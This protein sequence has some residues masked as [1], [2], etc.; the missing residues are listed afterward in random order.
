[1]ADLIIWNYRATRHELG[2]PA[3]NNLN[4][5]R[6]LGPHQL[7]CTLAKSGYE[8]KVIDF[9]G[10]MSTNDLV[11]ITEK[12]ITPTTIAIGANSS[13]WNTYQDSMME[14]PQW[15]VLA[16]R[17]IE[18]RYPQLNW[19]L[20][21]ANVFGR[22]FTFK[23][24][25]FHSHAENSLLKYLDEKTES[26]VIRTPFEFTTIE[27]HYGDG[28]AISSQEALPIELA[29]GC[30]FKCSF[31]RYPLLGK[32]KGT[33]IR[34]PKL[35]E[36]ELLDL[37]NRFGT[38]RY[39]FIDDTVNESEEK[40]EA[41]A[42]TASRLPFKLEWVGY[43][44]LDLIASRPQT[45]DLLQQS[46]LKSAYFGMES[47]HPAAS[48]SVGK[49]WNGKHAKE[50]LLELKDKWK[51]DTTWSLTFIVG[52]TD[53]TNNSLN[54]TQQWCIDNEMYAWFW[55]P[56]DISISP[57]HIDK[58]VF[59]TKYAEYGYS[60]PNANDD[61]YWEN[62]NWTQRTAFE[63]QQELQIA[64]A[65]YEKLAAFRLGEFATMTGQSFDV[66]KQ[67]FMSDLDFGT[68]NVKVRAFVDQYI[69]AQLE[70]IGP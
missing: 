7:A 33:Y 44:R 3:D 60:F 58:S 46:G 62:K 22:M 31:C 56:L 35:I 39:Y 70:I 65:P 20:G 47:F 63:R 49:G 54:A 15:A 26:K 55:S 45:I 69:R 14:E 16:R 6:P 27:K 17:I 34:D 51:G 4:I 24:T 1:M 64:A 21:G 32:K 66:T 53:E 28:L 67:L 50:F 68:I 48:L 12:H 30:Q 13:F 38:T 11:A 9:C 18:S 59:D 61:T 42:E 19:I 43:N 29:R 52:L 23:W 8:V 41:L 40:I 36:A 5:L 2:R 57:H 37:F 10:M 25:K